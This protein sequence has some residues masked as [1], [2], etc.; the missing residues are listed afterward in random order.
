NCLE[1]FNKG[2][3]YDGVYR[4]D[5]GNQSDPFEVYCDQSTDGGGW[6][7][8]QRRFDGKENFIRKWC[9]Y[10]H[11]FGNLSGEFWLGLDKI[12]RLTS[13]PVTL[14]VD[15]T[16]A[17][18]EKRFAQFEGFSVG[19]AT[20]KYRLTSGIYT[21]GTAGDSLSFSN[22]AMFS[23]I[24]QDNDAWAASSCAQEFKGA[25]WHKSCHES[26]L[27]GMYRNGSHPAHFADGV[28][29]KSWKDYTYSMM[30][31][32]MMIRTGRP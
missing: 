32:K 17:D 22:G 11:G 29:W 2:D 6:T 31:T 4:I 15:L 28:I 24:D 13:S 16:A 23:T 10:R 20:I 8:L 21:A 26:S 30:E 9:D 19:N 25:W 5:A 27:N 12:H 7:I 3:C 14:R 18:G 1:L